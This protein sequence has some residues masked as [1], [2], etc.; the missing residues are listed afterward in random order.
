MARGKDRHDA[1]KAAVAG[2][3]KVLSRRAGSACE[4]CGESL[5]LRPIE[6]PPTAEE[7]SAEA[8]MLACARCRELVEAKRLPRE[9]QDL[10]FLEKAAWADPVPVKLSAVRLLRRLDAEGVGWATELLDGLW[11]PEEVEALL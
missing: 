6:V 8:A 10:R 1:H 5:D 4:L 3:G 7:P 2:L 11:M 9:T